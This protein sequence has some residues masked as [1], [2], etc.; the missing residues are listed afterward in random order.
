MAELGPTDELNELFKRRDCWIPIILCCCNTPLLA[1]PSH[2]VTLSLHLQSPAWSQSSVFT[3]QDTRRSILTDLGDL[4]IGFRVRGFS[5][6]VKHCIP[7]PAWALSIHF[8][9]WFVPVPFLSLKDIYG[10]ILEH[11]PHLCGLNLSFQISDNL[12][13]SM[14]GGTFFL[15][16][17]RESLW[18]GHKDVLW[19][20]LRLFPV[21]CQQRWM[22]AF[23]NAV[24]ITPSVGY[25]SAVLLDLGI[26]QRCALK[27]PT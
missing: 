14:E 9:K 20:V 4:N 19:R 26:D 18:W 21:N 2:T 5:G 22:Q 24:S 6:A 3:I 10:F 7:H 27:A 1:F 15:G 8:V 16:G 17:G 25:Q 12:S 11:K 13:V 23:L